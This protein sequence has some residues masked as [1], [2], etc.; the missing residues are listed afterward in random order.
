MKGAQGPN[1][2]NTDDVKIKR[3]TI[4]I[5]EIT[6]A[7]LE[8]SRK[9]PS[10]KKSPFDDI[11]EVSTSFLADDETFP[12]D[13]KKKKSLIIALLLSLATSQVVYSNIATFLP[14][15]RTEKHPNMNDTEVGI[16][17]A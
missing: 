9:K 1:T 3:L 6:L 4:Y 17:L 2:N 10:S 11:D 5:Q 16:I 8:S 14:P 7:T 13:P 15:F 12:A